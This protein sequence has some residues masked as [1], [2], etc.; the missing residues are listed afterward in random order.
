MSGIPCPHALTCIWA[1][2][3][4]EYDFVDTWLKKDAQVAAYSGMIEPMTSPDKWPQPGLNPIQP[5]SD[6][7]LPGRPKKK[8]NKG[9]DEPAP[10]HVK[11]MSK[12]GVVIHCSKCKQAGHTKTT[13]HNEAVVQ[14]FGLCIYF[15]YFNS[16]N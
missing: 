14:V 1:S 12:T 2:G 9:N 16:V 3:L 6:V 8:R 5:P 15:N 11:K 10:G 4:K 7:S 13:C